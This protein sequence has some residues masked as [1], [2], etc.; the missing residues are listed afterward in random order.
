[1]L[2]GYQVAY[3]K[4]QIALISIAIII[5]G[6]A[7]FIVATSFSFSYRAIIILVG[8]P[9]VLGILIDHRLAV[10][11]FFVTLFVPFDI[12]IFTLPVLMPPILFLSFMLWHESIESAVEFNALF[13]PFLIS[14]LLMLPSLVNAHNIPF[15]LFRSYNYLSIG[16]LLITLPAF[17]STFESVKKALDIFVIV[18]VIN[19][20]HVIFET[21]YYNYRSFGFPGIVYVDFASLSL[22]ISI[23]FLLKYG[24][25]KY[26]IY[27]ALL[28]LG[29]VFTQTRNVLLSLFFAFSVYLFLLTRYDFGIDKKKVFSRITVVIVGFTGIILLFI[30]LKPEVFS[31][32]IGLVELGQGTL[33]YEAD[34]GKNSFLTR[35]LLW[36]TAVKA[37][38]ANPIFGMGIYSFPFDS[39]SYSELTPFLFNSYVQGLSTHITYLSILTEAGIVGFIGFCYFLVKTFNFGLGTLKVALVEQKEHAYLVLTVLV[40]YSY[41][42]FSMFLSDAWLIGQCAMIWASVMVLM[43]SLDNQFKSKRI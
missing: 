23:L 19:V 4:K 22:V 1:M 11:A 40:L 14:Y 28:L 8:L 27:A 17:F 38:L 12:S 29:M 3:T 16:L 24:E 26:L 13:K 21:F 35:V 39:K 2:L 30:I 36:Y 37:F 10:L 15:S 43:V 18:N 31:R 41:I 32:L 5:L 9:L 42:L 6:L 34:F 25:K 33:L 7:E 20:F